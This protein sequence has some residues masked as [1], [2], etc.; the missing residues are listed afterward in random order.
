MQ[1]TNAWNANGFAG[2][3]FAFSATAFWMLPV[4]LDASVLKPG[5]AMAKVATVVAAGFLAR[6][7]WRPAGVV[8]QAFF[9][10]NWFWMGVFVGLLYQQAPEQLCSV[11]LADQQAHAGAVIMAWAVAGLVGWLWHV[12]L[13]GLRPEALD[14]SG[15]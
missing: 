4:A 15:T 9:V 13:I 6:L 10:L 2:L 11:Y 8:I 7:S 14:D 5:V 1:R 12:G 3:L